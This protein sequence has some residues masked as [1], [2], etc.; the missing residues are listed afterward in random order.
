MGTQVQDISDH[1]QPHIPQQ[2]VRS[3]APYDR[4]S[5]SPLSESDIRQAMEANGFSSKISSV[6]FF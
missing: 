2:E 6:L 1:E 4:T 5:M 3:P